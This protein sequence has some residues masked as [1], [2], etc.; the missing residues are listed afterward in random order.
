LIV[1]DL[2]PSALMTRLRGQGLRLRTGPVVANVRSELP[3]VA[4]G[5]ALHYAQHEI[6]DEGFADFHVAVERPGDLR[7][8]V[9]PQAVFR[10][11]DIEPFKPQPVDHGFPMLEWGLNWCV[12]NH[13][14]QYL[15]LHAAVL[16]R[17]GRALILPAPS[18]SGK[19][20]LCAGL[21]YRGGWRLLSDE[22]AL[23]EPRSG[24]LVPLPRPVSLKNESIDLMRAFA[25]EAVLGDVVSDTTKGRVAHVRPP[26]ESV[27]NDKARPVPAW[28]VLPQFQSGAAA[29]L[30][31]VSRART[32]MT[33]IE[34]SFNYEVHGRRGFAALGD[35]I[36]RSACFSFVYGGDLDTALGVFDRLATLQHA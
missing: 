6:D 18:G 15:I 28:V 21:V 33:L 9:R 36:D 4:R 1:A 7:R 14:H 23:I 20:T 3:L 24:C 16:E 27:R 12:S 26:V 13:C 35:L 30:T 32:F 22:L 17:D 19:S 10:F 31:S 5:V 25:P 8:W 34:D 29:E 2:D 11:D